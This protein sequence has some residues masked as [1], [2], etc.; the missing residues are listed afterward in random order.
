MTIVVSSLAVAFA[1][2]CIWLTIRFVN[3]RERWAKKTL[4]A[5][6]AVP[7]LYLL[8]FGPACWIATRYQPLRKSVITIYSDTVVWAYFKTPRFVG[9]TLIWYANVAGDVDIYGMDRVGYFLA[10]RSE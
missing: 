6:I 7:M 3:R 5:I 9:S 10:F 8:S 2:V 4:V 1:S